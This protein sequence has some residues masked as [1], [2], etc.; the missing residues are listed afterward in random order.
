MMSITIMLLWVMNI[1]VMVHC[2][3]ADTLSASEA[4]KLVEHMRSGDDRLVVP[5]V[6]E[7]TRQRQ[8]DGGC[9][10]MDEAIESIIHEADSSAWAAQYLSTCV[11]SNEE[12]RDYLAHYSNEFHGAVVEMLR[13]NDEMEM[14]AA[15]ELIWIAT[16][17]HGDH[18]LE[19][20]RA[21]VIQALADIILQVQDQS[22]YGV[23][24]MWA[25]VALQNLAANYCDPYCDYVW[26]GDPNEIKQ[27]VID[28]HSTPVTVE[29]TAV[30]KRI[31]EIDGLL[32]SLEKMACVGPVWEPDGEIPW[33]GSDATK[34][35]YPYH[36]DS[37]YPSLV[38]WAA[39]GLLKNLAL[40]PEARRFLEED[41]FMICMCRLAQSEDWLEQLK[42]NQFFYH[43]RPDYPCHYYEDEDAVCIDLDGFVDDEGYSCS[44]YEQHHCKEHGDKVGVLYDLT[45]NDACCVCN[46]GE[47]F[48]PETYPEHDL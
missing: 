36:V 46:G 31:L 47:Y 48:K 4:Y 16:F 10:K 30:R 7:E 29:G 40:L 34:W 23:I 6:S 13:S 19:F 3:N 32:D 15:S 1:L 2:A 38:S 25:A 45:V 22:D 24:Q 37:S 26:E 11:N 5:S 9:D 8:E 42:A 17:N 43:M 27:L 39:A 18:I 12:N 21:D 44:G 41:D 14:A 20:M 33:P 35:N 28:Q